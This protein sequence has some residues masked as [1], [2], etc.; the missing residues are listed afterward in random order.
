[1]YNKLLELKKKDMYVSA[2][3]D[4]EDNDSFRFGKIDTVDEEFLL[5]RAYTPTG[6]PN[7]LYM[8]P[9]AHIIRLEYGDPYSERMKLLIGN[10]TGVRSGVS[11]PILDSMLLY[12]KRSGRVA[13]FELNDSG[14]SDVTGIVE[15]I[16]QDTVTVRQIDLY[17]CEDG[18]TC[19]RIDDIS[20]IEYDAGVE[21]ARSKLYEMKRE[22]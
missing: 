18:F 1:M 10:V 8:L 21:S 9:L 15:S 7:G 16:D 14:G 2:Y 19:F 5:L 22:R 13:S 17:G 20:C 3:N 6:T 12:C 11:E 4:A